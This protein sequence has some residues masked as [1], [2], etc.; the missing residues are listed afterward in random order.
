MT[1]V[2]G[3]ARG[4]MS[5]RLAGSLHPVVTARASSLNTRVIESDVMPRTRRVACFAGFARRYMPE[6]RLAGSVDTVVAT[7]AASRNA[8][9]IEPGSEPGQ[10]PVALIANKGGLRVVSGLSNCGRP[11]VTVDTA[12]ENG[13]MVDP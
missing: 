9:V 8:R 13:R 5:S 4:N 1:R 3:T 2:A 12:T 11:V 7:L 6:R 10:R